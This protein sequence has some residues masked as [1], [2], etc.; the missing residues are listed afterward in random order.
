MP[1]PPPTQA[2]F[3]R[4]Y[5]GPPTAHE[6]RASLRRQR[7]FM[8]AVALYFLV[9]TYFY[10]CL[11]FLLLLLLH[12]AARQHNATSGF[13]LLW[14]C[15]SETRDTRIKGDLEIRSDFEASKLFLEID[16]KAMKNVCPRD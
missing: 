12:G 5:G 16:W 15:L 11:F 6:S 1:L 3:D 14:Y 9:F 8:P 7:F 2:S 13:N 10:Y 4:V